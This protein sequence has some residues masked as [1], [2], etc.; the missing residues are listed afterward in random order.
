[1]IKAKVE[2]GKVRVEYKGE[3]R[4]IMKELAN[5]VYGVVI[6]GIAANHEKNQK[7]YFINETT[8]EIQEALYLA[9]KEN[10]LFD[11]E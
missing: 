8:K 3:A 2:K 4:E 10:N 7:E 5:I 6:K 11:E 9:I 1:M